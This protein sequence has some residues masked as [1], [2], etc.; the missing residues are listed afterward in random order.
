MT[1]TPSQR[2]AGPAGT[3]GG[4][5]TTPAEPG[6]SRESYLP[7]LAADTRTFAQEANL[8]NYLD[9]VIDRI[10]AE[11]A[12]Q[13]LKW[14]WLDNPGCGMANGTVDRKITILIEEVGEVARAIL[15]GDPIRHLHEELIQVA[16]V[17]AAWVQADLER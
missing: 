10:L 1:T 15:E 3:T 13:D 6:L 14:G 16:A 11:R 2:S 5:I 17:A 4:F 8:H 7:L 12:N 9:E